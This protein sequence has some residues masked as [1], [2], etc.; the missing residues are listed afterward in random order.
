[1]AETAVGEGE[2]GGGAVPLI[3]DLSQFQNIESK[4][5]LF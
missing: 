4:D 1:V 3:E 2:E 5:L